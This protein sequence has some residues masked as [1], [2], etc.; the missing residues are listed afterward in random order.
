ME[1]Q[2]LVGAQGQHGVSAPMESANSTSKASDAYCST[3]VPT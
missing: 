3:T 1:D 2:E